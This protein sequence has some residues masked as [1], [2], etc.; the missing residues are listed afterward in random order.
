[1]TLPSRVA[2]LVIDVRS[3]VFAR[4]SEMPEYRE[5]TSRCVEAAAI[6]FAR[7]WKPGGN[8]L[9]LPL[10]ASAAISAI[11]AHAATARRRRQNACRWVP[12]RIIHRTNDPPAVE[13]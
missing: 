10:L 8:R 13:L 12:S 1:M 2:R 7:P 9:M 6:S 4:R 3:Y 5:F 11:A